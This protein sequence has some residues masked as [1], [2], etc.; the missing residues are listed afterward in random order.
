MTHRIVVTLAL[1]LGFGLVQAEEAAQAPAAAVSSEATDSA[2]QTLLAEI[3]KVEEPAMLTQ[4]VARF[5]QQGDLEAEL[6]AL[7]RRIAL[8]PHMG[9][10]R[11]DKV[12]TLAREDRKSEAYTLLIDLQ[13]TGYAYDLRGDERFANIATTQVWDYIVDNFDANRA[14][15]GEGTVLHTLPRE[16]L[17][18]ESVGWDA[19]R[20][21][22]L[23][24]G[25]REGKVY[26]VEKDGKL[27]PLV[28]ADADNGMWAVLDFVVDAKRG[29]LWV[30]SSAVPH[31]KGYKP[32]VDV[33]RAGIFKFDLKTGKFIRSF[34][35]PEGQGNIFMLASLALGVDGEI[36]ALD[37]INSA[38]Y[39]VRDDQFRRLV[40]APA[41][42]AMRA[43]TV[44]GDGKN[45]YLADYERGI[46]GIE[47][48]TLKAF[49]VR[50]PT[51]LSLQGIEALFWFEGSLVAVQSGMTPPRVMRF[52]LSDDGST[53]TGVTPVEASNPAFAKVGKA[54]MDG[55]SIYVV[56][57]SQLDNYDR[58]GL[59]RN[60]DQL[61]GTRIIRI[62]A[63]YVPPQAQ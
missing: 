51:K 56:G 34:L 24:G 35:S 43:L 55:S 57:N 33:G 1:A 9:A 8:R 49:D 13:N 3:A 54:A 11:L 17:L 15:Y 36:Y 6:A 48:A 23:V 4:L 41:F 25:A 18:I 5:R 42:P 40:H 58:F 47:L 29:F 28:S 19:S 62:D 22:L 53:I 31:F 46:V 10:Y 32:G 52:G 39:Q 45:L 37:I 60:K 21:Q 38:L 12:V 63:D 27:V 2:R 30:A 16:D 20:K 7:D 59:V 61:E 44:S 14:P 50:V 26:R